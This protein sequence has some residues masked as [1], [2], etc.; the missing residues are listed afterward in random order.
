MLQI[1]LS[2]LGHIVVAASHGKEG[3][4]QL[5][6]QKFDLVI[7]D[8]AMP[9][10]SG[11]QISRE[12]KSLRN[13]PVMLLTGFGSFMDESPEGID[14]VIGKPVTSSLLAGAIEKCMESGDSTGRAE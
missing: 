5:S 2:E 4:V 12:I 3:L 14:H 6:K 1:L 8:Q 11:E 9:D 13:I 10:M 7:T